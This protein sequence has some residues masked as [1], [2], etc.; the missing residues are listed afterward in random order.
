MLHLVDGHVQETEGPD[1][2]NSPRATPFKFVQLWNACSPTSFRILGAAKDAIWVSARQR[3][4]STS[5]P[6][7]GV[8]ELTLLRPSK[9]ASPII[10]A[11]GGHANVLPR[12]GPLWTSDASLLNYELEMNRTSWREDWL[13]VLYTSTL[14][15][16][17]GRYAFSAA[18]A[19][20]V[21]IYVP[22][23]HL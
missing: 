15:I 1:L 9:A 23:R 8:S 20:L 19:L 7:F 6:S 14:L 22:S 10:R 3:L 4:P 13:D 18:P 11:V 5:S 16:C 21:W 17:S 12:S 2:A